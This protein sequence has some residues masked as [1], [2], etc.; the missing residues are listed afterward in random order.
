LNF[1]VAG[2]A[3][4]EAG[5]TIQKSHNVKAEEKIVKQK[6]V[7]N[8]FDKVTIKTDDEMAYDQVVIKERIIQVSGH[9]FKY[10]SQ[11]DENILVAKD[12]FLCLDRK[13][14]DSKYNYMIQVTDQK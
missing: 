10:D 5:E 6:E 4:A 11:R 12:T 13:D 3:A 2:A 7:L 14:G 1:I 8:H 9:L